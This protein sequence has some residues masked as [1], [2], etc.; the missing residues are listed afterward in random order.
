MPAVLLSSGR[1]GMLAKRAVE[2][3]SEFSPDALAAIVFS[4][5][6]VEA[7]ANELLHRFETARHDELTEP[8]RRLRT[9][10]NAAD[11]SARDA[12][13]DVKVQVIAASLTGSPFDR[14]RQPFQD[15]QLLLR[16]RNDLVHHRPETV[17]E[18]EVEHE[19][20]PLIIPRQLHER[21]KSL[22]SRGIIK[23]PDA[24][25]FYSLVSLL[26]RPQVAQWAFET[27]ARMIRALADTLPSEGWRI[28]V[29]TGQWALHDQPAA[30]SSA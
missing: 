2:R 15:F 30:G 25:V 14:G 22:V 16:L 26:E 29:L 11:L 20:A 27:A 19:G 1:F 4:A 7:F 23:T 12:R 5:L 21:V 9:M 18:V 24:K 6:W 17:D 10:A 8:L 28:L 3:S 13:L